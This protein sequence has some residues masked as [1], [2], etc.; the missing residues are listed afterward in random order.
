[1]TSPSGYVDVDDDTLQAVLALWATDNVNLPGLFKH[2]PRTGRLK[3]PEPIPYV[4]VASEFVRSERAFKTL[5]D[6]RKVT[7]TIRGVKADVTKGLG[8]VQAL[9]NDQV[10]FPGNPVLVYP[11]GA[12]FIKWW[13]TNR[14]TLKQ[15]ETTKEALDVWM[16]VIE[17]EVTSVRQG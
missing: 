12:R 4:H 17:A 7:I 6:V 15:D 8:F 9:F 13:P 5:K 10:G 16:G 1:M 2:P 11:S 3:H 14:G